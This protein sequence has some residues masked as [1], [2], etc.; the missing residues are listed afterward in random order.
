MLVSAAWIVPAGFAVI[1]R[2]AQ[3]HLNGWGPMPQGHGIE[4]T[5][6][7][8]RALY[9]ARTSLELTRRAEGGTIATLRVPYREMIPEPNRDAS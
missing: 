7:R 6:E 8:L 2:I 9:G 1:N 5:R 3:T 4:N